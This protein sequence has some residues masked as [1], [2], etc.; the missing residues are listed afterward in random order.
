MNCP[1][2]GRA[3]LTGTRFCGNCG[4]VIIG[5]EDQSPVLG[6][7]T[8]LDAEPVPYLLITAGPGRGQ[9]FELRGEVHLG[10]SRINAVALAD[11]KVSRNHARLDPIRSTYIL[12]DLGSA[13]GTFVNGV[14]VT[15]PVR[16]RDGDLLQAGDTQLVFRSHPAVHPPQFDRAVD[17][18]PASTVPIADPEPAQGDWSS[19]LAQ[20]VRPPTWTWVGC[21]AL[22]ILILLIAVAMTTGIL[23]GQGL[24]GG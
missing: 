2:C 16:L 13:N 21:V 8:V 19:P 23:I 20:P 9:T 22:I 14:R 1:A 15:Q 24:G 17:Y 11:G 12:T 18:S 4:S 5:D 3:V 10:R 7:Y 6:N